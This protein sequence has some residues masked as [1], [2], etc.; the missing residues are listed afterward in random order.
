[1]IKILRN[2]DFNITDF[3]VDNVEDVNELKN[4]NGCAAGSTAY[5]V[6]TGETYIKKNNG[7][8]V[9][10]IE[11][12][13][14]ETPNSG[15]ATGDFW[16]EGDELHINVANYK[17]CSEYFNE[18]FTFPRTFYVS[19][20]YGN[21]EIWKTVTFD[22]PTD[23]IIIDLSD[24]QNHPAIRICDDSEYNYTI[25]LCVSKTDNGNAVYNSFITFDGGNG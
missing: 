16:F 5:I 10:K 15:G 23:E 6:T 8:W 24:V 17:K 9:E 12:I 11:T 19:N 21:D 3:L 20:D 25:N 13:G 1:M 7:D 18:M 2:K 22:E 14:N 4:T